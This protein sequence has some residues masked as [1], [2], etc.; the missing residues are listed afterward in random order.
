MESND[1]APRTGSPR[2][3]RAGLAAGMSIKDAML[4]AAPEWTEL[5]DDAAAAG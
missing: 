2:I 4:G 5:S 1:G 3:G